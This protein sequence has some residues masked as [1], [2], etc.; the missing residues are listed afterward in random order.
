MLPT[1]N[2]AENIGPL[3]DAILAQGPELEVLVVDDDSPDRTWK[4]VQE[5][6]KKDSRVHLLL[7]KTRR[8]RGL[9]GIAGFCEALRL[10]AD[11]VI[12]MDADWS[13]DP[14]WIPAMIAQ[15]RSA[16][17]VIGSRLAPGGGEEG[18]SFVRQWITRAANLY[19]RTMLRLPVRD[20]TSGYRLFSR[21]C[22]EAIPWNAMRATGPEVVQEVLLAAHARGFTIAE[23]PILFV[24][25]RHGQST[26]NSK[27]MIRS[28]AAMYRL[29]KHP[30]RLVPDKSA[31]GGIASEALRQSLT[32]LPAPLTI[33]LSW[34]YGL[35]RKAHRAWNVWGPLKREKLPVAVVCVGNLTVGGTGKTPFVQFMAETFK[36]RGFKPAIVSRGY[37]AEER[38]KAPL[39]VSDGERMLATA[40]QAG[41]EP[42]WLAEHCP[43][44]PVVVCPDR[45]RAGLLAS[46]RLG[47]DLIILDDGF[48]HDR[49]RRN[50]DLVLWDVGDEPRR[51]RLLPAGRLREGLGALRRADAIVLTHGEY[52]PEPLRQAG[53]EEVIHQLK[54][55]VPAVA[56]FEA[57]TKLVGYQ[58]LSGRI[59]PEAEEAAGDEKSWPWTG[60]R[61]ICVSGLARPQG[62]EAMVKASGG[63]IVQHFAYPDHFAH[64]AGLAGTW[65][66]A[67]ERHGAEMILTTNKDAVKLAL[68][69]L[70]GLPILAV[71]IAM[72]I[73]DT[74][75]W[76]AFLK[77]RLKKKKRA[78]A[79]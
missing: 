36:N 43:G 49:L 50:L 34:L 24:E 55:R 5:R 27:I 62:F 41:D 33:P 64:H 31:E 10:G 16:D 77:Q 58:K 67:M 22:L 45:Y 8:G 69:P 72:A 7:R 74:G 46:Q 3:I 51:M 21:R 13:H 70:F 47:A 37:H 11:A 42:Q 57:E 1:Y 68:L 35:G 52:L 78:K 40:A 73:K 59:R 65:R 26:F 76:E 6:E 79:E 32:R 61:V 19:I 4:I 75:R 60:R 48:Q 28:L 53:T 39:V 44:V 18:R 12:E 30:G 38:L 66:E 15:G 23:V 17:V 9:A 71:S 54:R 2:E 25:R 14:K 56:I 20:A 63:I 29:R